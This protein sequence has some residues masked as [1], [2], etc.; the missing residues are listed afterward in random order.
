MWGHRAAIALGSWL[1]ISLVAASASGAPARLRVTVTRDGLAETRVVERTTPRAG[2]PVT[3]AEP[4]RLSGDGWSLQ[5]VVAGSQELEQA[6]S[7]ADPRGGV[8]I[9]TV[10]IGLAAGFVNVA[11]VPLD[12]AFGVCIDG[13]PVGAGAVYGGSI[14]GSLLDGDGNG[15]GSLTTD[16]AMNPI[17]HLRMASAPCSEVDPGTTAAVASL[18]PHP[19]TFNVPG[20]YQGLNVP[21]SFFGGDP[22]PN[23]AGPL[24]STAFE[25]LVRYRV[26]PGEFVGF[27]SMGTL[28]GDTSA[29]GELPTA[30]LLADEESPAAGALVPRGVPTPSP[31]LGPVRT[32]GLA[33][34]DQTD[35]DPLDPEPME[36]FNHNIVLAVDPPVAAPSKHGGVIL[37]SMTDFSGTS[38]TT[39][40]V[41]MLPFYRASADDVVRGSLYPHPTAFMA[42]GFHSTVIPPLSFGDDAGPAIT[43]SLRLDLDYQLVND[44]LT[45]FLAL[46]VV[47][48]CATPSYDVDGNGSV[49]ALTDGLLILRFLFG[50]TGTSLTNG[51][52]GAG[53]TRTDPADIVA[54]LQC[55]A[56]TML[57]VD[58]NGSL[59]ALTDGLLILRRLFGLSGTTLT[60]AVL[61]AGA[62]RTDPTDIAAFI[63]QFVP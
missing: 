40:T 43:S 17:Y 2:A 44:C 25:M 22:I 42:S 38:C 19:Q 59:S 12:V 48:A 23:A 15:T 58:A 37:G 50:L 53:A 51:A 16:S 34:G 49:T 6:P 52:L 30:A 63:A 7:G 54:Y 55:L 24:T 56:S 21:E 20:V 45:T 39:Q 13:F 14:A 3:A 4:V 10:G 35:F 8:T 57:D 62:T 46:Y 28:I 47:P 31:D 61:G 27:T 18:R 36:P 33:L 26:S 9:F 41:N 32:L 5:G 60:N 29:A 1:S 11:E